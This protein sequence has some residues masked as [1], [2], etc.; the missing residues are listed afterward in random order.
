MVYFSRGDYLIDHTLVS[1][2]ISKRKLDMLLKNNVKAILTEMVRDIIKLSH[3]NLK[4]NDSWVTG[5]LAQSG[6]YSYDPTKIAATAEFRAP[7]AAAVEYGTDPHFA[8]LGPD[9][10]Y[11]KT[12]SGELVLT[13]TPS[14]VTNPLDYYA[15]R[16]LGKRE[17]AHCKW[18]KRYYG[19]HTIVGFGIW[20]AIG[21]KGTDPH[22]YFRPAIDEVTLNK[23]KYI[24]KHQLE[25]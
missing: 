21:L 14:N 10:D 11:K 9:V 24:A 17:I 15:V 23:D 18:G 7:Y 2:E 19:V 4:K 3:E 1:R 8:P 6:N 25:F 20:K 12:R 16:K 22:P 5:Q 13:G